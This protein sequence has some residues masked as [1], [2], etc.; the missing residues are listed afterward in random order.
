MYRFKAKTQVS[1]VEYFLVLTLVFQLGLLLEI[2]LD[3]NLFLFELNNYS[4]Y[5]LNMSNNNDNSNNSNNSLPKYTNIP[6]SD[7]NY[8]SM[9]RTIA[10][11]AAAL[12]AK[13]PRTRA[14]SLVLGNTYAALTDIITNEERASPPYGGRCKGA[15]GPFANYWIDQYNHYLRYGR[16]R[17]GQQGEGPFER[18]FNPFNPENKFD[19]SFGNYSYSSFVDSSDSVDKNIIQKFLSPVEH[20][21]PLETL[22]NQHFLII[23]ALFVLVLAL[24]ML[25][26]FFYLDLIIIFNKDYFLNKVSNK[27]IKMYAKYV[28]LKTKVNLIV[29][30][31]IIVF[32][33]LI[34]ARGPKGPL[35]SGAPRPTLIF[36]II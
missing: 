25:V 8:N 4:D 23:L 10:I 2:L 22:I 11:N 36:C 24:I 18:E 29:E 35:T 19:S 1:Y 34:L 6:H 32:T 33:L 21:I 27:Y 17:G 7:N 16:L 5:I 12:A 13:T 3:N 9:I 15:S 14:V 20:S 26:L 30:A 31:L 28:L